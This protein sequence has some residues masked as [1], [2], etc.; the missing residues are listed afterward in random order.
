MVLD[1]FVNRG[2]WRHLQLIARYARVQ[3][4]LSLPPS[5]IC[6]VRQTEGRYWS[7]GTG[8]PRQTDHTGVC[9]VSALGCTP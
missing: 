7:R 5:T 8:S 9:I 6:T 3:V 4:A 1:H 2:S